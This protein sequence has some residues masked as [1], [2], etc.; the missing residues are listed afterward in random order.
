MP[1]DLSPNADRD[2]CIRC[3]LE[4]HEVELSLAEI[5]STQK[6]RLGDHIQTFEVTE[7][8]LDKKKKALQSVSEFNA[9]LEQK[10]SAEINQISVPCSEIEDAKLNENIA[11]L[12]HISQ[13]KDRKLDE[14]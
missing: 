1:K 12:T 3:I 11:I 6:I 9:G 7:L 8:K 13:I 5:I 14:L 4:S 10:L 2:E